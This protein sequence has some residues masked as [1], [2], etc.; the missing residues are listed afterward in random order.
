MSGKCVPNSF[1]KR[2]EI[3]SGS[4]GFT[5]HAIT[6]TSSSF[7][8]GSGRG[9]SSYFNTSGAPYSCATTAFIMSALICVRATAPRNRFNRNRMGLCFLL[10]GAW[11]A[12][13][14]LDR[15]IGKGIHHLDLVIGK[16]IDDLPLTGFIRETIHDLDAQI[17]KTGHGLNLV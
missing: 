4:A 1:A 8:F 15:E 9:A 17:G 13:H 11:K 14:V 16:R 12:L 7:S 6:R 10:C 3:T 5:P 2:P